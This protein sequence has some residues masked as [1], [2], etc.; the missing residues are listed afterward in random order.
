MTGINVPELIKT[1]IFR[2][3]HP[4]GYRDIIQKYAERVK[5]TTGKP[6]NGAILS[7][8]ARQF[9]FDRVK[10]IQMYVNKLVKKGR[11]PQELAAEYEVN[12]MEEDFQLD[13]KIAGLVKKSE[14]SKVPYGIL[15]KVYNRGMAAWRTGHRPGTT[16]Q[17]W[18]FARVN[19]ML[20]GGKAD[21]DLQK[22][23]RASKK[24]KK[25]VMGY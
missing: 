12:D 3:T 2:L 22:Q 13:E 15:K 1:T 9:G 24:K 5:Q 11:L 17:Q 14:K 20:T 8:I 16:P 19:S 7:D 6:S 18:A 23:A 10:P 25:K 4:K 21:P